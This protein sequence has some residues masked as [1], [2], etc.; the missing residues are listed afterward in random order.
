[1]FLFCRRF[2]NSV[3][4]VVAVFRQREAVPPQPDQRRRAGPPPEVAGRGRRRL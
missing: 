4:V 1:M 3:G 2:G